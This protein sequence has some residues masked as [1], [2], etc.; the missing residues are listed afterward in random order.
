MLVV[1]ETWYK[2]TM[3][4]NNFSTHCY[5]QQQKWQI[6]CTEDTWVRDEFFFPFYTRNVEKKAHNNVKITRNQ[7]KKNRKSRN[8]FITICKFSKYILTISLLL[9]AR[10]PFFSSWLSHTITL[11]AS[12]D[13][14]I[15]W[16]VL[17][18]RWN[19]KERMYNRW[20]VSYR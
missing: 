4:N 6:S 11:C 18:D 16:C 17:A 15:L 19:P 10:V 2:Q 14:H 3:I 1:I 13:Y 5:E 7:Q 8:N 20:S 9:D 12:L